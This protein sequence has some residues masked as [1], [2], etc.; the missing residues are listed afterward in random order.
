MNLA[1]KKQ[2]SLIGHLTL[3]LSSVARMR[4]KTIGVF[5]EL[6][7]LIWSLWFSSEH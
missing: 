3:C 4:E 6:H 7:N 2:S 5:G 1:M